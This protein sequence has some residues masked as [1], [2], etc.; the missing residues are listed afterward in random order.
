MLTGGLILA[1]VVAASD[2]APACSAKYELSHEESGQAQLVFRV[3]AACECVHDRRSSLREFRV[4]VSG[5]KPRAEGPQG[6]PKPLVVRQG[7]E[8]Q[9]SWSKQVSN[10]NSGEVLEFRLSEVPRVGALGSEALVYQRHGADYGDCTVGGV[11]GGVL[12]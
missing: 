2:A 12:Y 3:P 1:A 7:G 11:R 4:I 10:P 9:S 8:W 6:W 5:S